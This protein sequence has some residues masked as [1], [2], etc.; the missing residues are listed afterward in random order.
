M[1]SDSSLI[2]HAV[3][4]CAQMVR[5]NRRD[6][7]WSFVGQMFGLGSTSSCELCKRL[8]F[9]PCMTV[10]DFLKTHYEEPKEQ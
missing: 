1:R 4:N 10:G 3:Q 8:G 2:F 5:G 7:L 9:N 6:V